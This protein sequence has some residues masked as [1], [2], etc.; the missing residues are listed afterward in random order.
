[1][2]F[3]LPS[4]FSARIN[5]H[6]LTRARFNTNA[7]HIMSTQQLYRPTQHT[8]FPSLLLTSRYLCQSCH[9]RARSGGERACL[10]VRHRKIVEWH[11][12]LA[13][14]PRFAR[15]LPALPLRLHWEPAH[16]WRVGIGNSPT[17]T[18]LL[19]LHALQSQPIFIPL[20]LSLSCTQRYLSNTICSLS[21]ILCIWHTLSFSL[22][23]LSCW[24]FSSHSHW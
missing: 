15:T 4:T 10:L 14:A 23:L 3:H 19:I 1:M 16:E 13:V 11:H 6:L 5:Y 21:S 20:T 24:C 12:C 2:F 7:L 8:D 9:T 22:L 17:H 18:H